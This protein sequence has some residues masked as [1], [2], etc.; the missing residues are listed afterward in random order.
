M[1][2]VCLDLKAA[3]S[4]NGY[5]QDERKSIIFL[6]FVEHVQGGGN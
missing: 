2:L 3:Q 4:G 5:R 6:E 1:I